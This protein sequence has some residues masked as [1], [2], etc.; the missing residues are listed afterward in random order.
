MTLSRRGFVAGM[1]TVAV[2]RPFPTSAQADPEQAAPTD[3][4]DP[5]IEVDPE[6]L[7]HNVGVVSRLSGGRPILAVIKNN[8]YGL[9]LTAVAR[10]LEPKNEIAGFAVVKAEA[11]LRLREA[12]IRKPILL[13]G[14]FGDTDGAELVARGIH[15]SLTTDD[16]G[17]RARRAA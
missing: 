8:A 11:A 10:I 2:A 5:W 16:A 9:G 3:R 14:L 13:M 4:F 15:L 12:G 17:D 7:T 6:A 1:A